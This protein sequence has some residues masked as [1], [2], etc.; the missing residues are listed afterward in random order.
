MSITTSQRINQSDL[1]VLLPN[2]YSW[3]GGRL[4]NVSEKTIT[5]MGYTDQQVQSA[6]NTAAGQFVDLKLNLDTIQQNARTAYQNNVAY[7]NIPTPT[8]AQAAA[9]VQALTRQM[10][11]LIRVVIGDFTGS[12]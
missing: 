12:T 9:Q 2:G 4:E 5:G 1:D 10:N 11:G 3:T 6:I 8:Q 7:L